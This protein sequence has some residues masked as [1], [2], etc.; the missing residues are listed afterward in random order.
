LETVTL[1]ALKQAGS[2]NLASTFTI[3]VELPELA[4][5]SKQMLL[6]CPLFQL[7]LPNLQRAGGILTLTTSSASIT[8]L[9]KVSLPALEEA[10]N[11]A[12][13]AFPQCTKIDLPQLNKVAS[14]SCS[15]MAKLSLIYAPL[16]EE[17]TGLVYLYNLTVLTEFELPVLK[18]AGEINTTSCAQLRTLGFPK[19]TDATII[20][21]QSPPLSSLAGFSA[22]QTAG[23]VTLNNLQ[24]V[25]SL[26]GFSSL[27]NV[28]SIAL[29]TLPKV[30]SLD[31][32]SSL[33]T[34]GTVTLSSLQEV[35]SLAGF[36]SLQNVKSIA[37]ATLSKVTSLD[38][39]S[40]LQTAGTVTLTNL[41]LEKV[42]FPASV[43]RIDYL[44]VNLTASGIPAPSEINV[45]G[46]NIG[47]LNLM[48]NATGAGKL[49]GDEVFSGTLLI[50]MASA[51]PYPTQ[52][53]PLEGFGE[54][55]SLLIASASAQ[56]VHISGIRKI[57]RGFYM[58]TNYSG[59]PYE[60]SISDLEEVGGNFTVSYIM[61]NASAIFTAVR[62][63]EL[64]RVGGNFTFDVVTKSADT[65]RFPELTTVG[66][67][68]SL[69]SGYDSGTNYKSFHTVSLPKLTTVGGKLTLRAGTSTSNRNNKLTNLDGFAAL[70]GVGSIEITRH[71]ALVDYKGL[72]ELFKTL[73]AT[74]WIT[75]TNNSYN[76]TYQA[77]K[78][79]Q[80]T[81]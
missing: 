16:L 12:I 43:Q 36:S 56:K 3:V 65:L 60:F 63:D 44:T 20:N 10:G 68:F 58:G 25:T 62:F 11:I 28:K 30:T 74:G 78:D 33:Q 51:S 59:Y 42:E 24:E 52:I 64:K 23:T 55:D 26:A 69:N 15:S 66:G 57:K 14:L 40:S 48:G 76:P 45:K 21:L 79:G 54:V 70:A 9:D 35:T 6:N 72:E 53:P 49:I 67:N 31:G 71:S 4:E 34:A 46:I 37:L 41:S 61:T 1:P 27:Q 2:I 18:Q 77:L 8:S 19:L 50:N 47:T 7:Q 32:F 39:F 5:V 73:P 81:K 29:T 13:S 17:A 75:P 38:G 22:L 80:W